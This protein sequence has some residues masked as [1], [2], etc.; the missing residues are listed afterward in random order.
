MGGLILSD[1]IAFFWLL[2]RAIDEEEWNF[3]LIAVLALIGGFI[4]MLLLG[5]L[6]SGFAQTV[7]DVH[8]LRR[9]LVPTQETE[10]TGMPDNTQDENRFGSWFAKS[11]AMPKP[12]PK[13]TTPEKTAPSDRTVSIADEDEW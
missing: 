4:L 10:K 5:A 7:D 1:V 11:E 2:Y 6:L 12:E 8:D 9:H 13:K 3:A